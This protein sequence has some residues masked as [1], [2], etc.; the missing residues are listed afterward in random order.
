MKKIEEIE[1]MPLEERKNKEER[2][3][4]LS[5]FDEEYWTVAKGSQLLVMGNLKYEDEEIKEFCIYLVDIIAKYK[6]QK[7]VDEIIL[8]DFCKHPFNG[9]NTTLDIIKAEFLSIYN[10]F[11]KKFGKKEITPYDFI[12]Y[13]MTRYSVKVPLIM[14]EYKL[15]IDKK[16]GQDVDCQNAMQKENEH[17]KPR[18]TELET[19]LA[20]CREQSQNA[21][22]SAA[23]KA[24]QEKNLTEWKEAFK[25]MLPVILQC[26][27]EGPRPRTT[28]ELEKMCA[29]Y[30]GSLDK[31]KM[32]FLRECL[33]ECLGPEHVNTTGGPTIQG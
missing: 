15:H 14:E 27:E 5:E 10:I 23:T 33:I 21:K 18:I 17:L 8:T 16:I 3:I 1:S 25:A 12:T 31:S 11:Y 6:L 28:P 4:T 30:N 2:R 9:L 22:T 29:R 26:R 19:E 32:A 13:A 7:S 24:R 20:T